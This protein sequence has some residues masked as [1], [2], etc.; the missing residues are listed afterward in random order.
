MELLGYRAVGRPRGGE[1]K[2]DGFE[3]KHG[4]QK[5]DAVEGKREKKMTIS[6]TETNCAAQET[7]SRPKKTRQNQ[8]LV[9]PVTS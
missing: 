6:C 2:L 1:N 7:H 8:T 5:I 9:S 3:R 4:W